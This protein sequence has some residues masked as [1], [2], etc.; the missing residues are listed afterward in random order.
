[1]PRNVGTPPIRPSRPR[2]RQLGRVPSPLIGPQMPKP[3]V[4]LCRP[5]PMISVTARLISLA[6]AAWPI[7]SP[8]PKLWTPMPIAISSASCSAGREPVEPAAAARTRRARRR[9]GRRACV[10]RRSAR[11][12]HPLG[13]VDEAHQAEREAAQRRARRATR[14]GPSRCASSA[15][16]IGST[17]SVSTSQSRK[18]RIPVASALSPARAFALEAAH[19]ADRQAEEDRRARDRAEQED[20]WSTGAHFGVRVPLQR[21][22]GAI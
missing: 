17:A 9:R 12:L 11:A 20:L 6:A 18:T 19:P 16:S 3:S 21:A 2:S 1:M 4:A 7:A 10:A 8:S 13:V 5:K 14:T 22:R 15:D